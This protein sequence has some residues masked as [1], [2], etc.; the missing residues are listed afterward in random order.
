VIHFEGTYTNEFSANPEKTPLYN[1]NHIL[2]RL[3][4]AGAAVKRSGW[5]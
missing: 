4:L 3:D 5:R 1:Y 2:Y